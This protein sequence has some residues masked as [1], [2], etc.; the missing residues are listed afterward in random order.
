[1]ELYREMDDPSYTPKTYLMDELVA[2][3]KYELVIT[4]LKGG[5]FLRYRVGDVYRCLRLRNPSDK[6]DLPQFEY[7][8]RIP[9]VIDIA[10]FTRFT[11]REIRKVIEMSRLP[12]PDWFAT[13]EYDETG[14]SF[15]NLYVEVDMADAQGLAMSRQ[16]LRDH[17]SLYFRSYDGDYKDLKRLLNVDPL[18]ITTLKQGT[19]ALYQQRNG[20]KIPKVGAP[21]ETVLE[22]LRMQ[23]EDARKGGNADVLE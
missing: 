15:L 21:R 19:I 16:L 17:L 20:Q 13:K 11:E 9:S 14:R 8:D 18:K 7:V 2:G 10:G 4:V 6:L 22:I 1:M 5:A 3:Q 12:I 23:S